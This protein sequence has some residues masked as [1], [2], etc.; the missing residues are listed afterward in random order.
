MGFIRV[1]EVSV[2]NYEDPLRETYVNTANIIHFAELSY[3]DFCR[4]RLGQK[5]PAKISQNERFTEIYYGPHSRVQSM[6]VLGPPELIEHKI[7]AGAKKL[8][9]G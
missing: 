9:K 6:I 5:I 4:K 8:L 3:A 1:V 7:Y 2:V